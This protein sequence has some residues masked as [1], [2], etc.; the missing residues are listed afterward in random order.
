MKTARKTQKKTGAKPGTVTS[1]DGKRTIALEEFDRLFDEGSDEVDQ[2]LDWKNAKAVS[3][4][5]L[6][7]TK[8]NVDFPKWVVAALD[9]EADRIGVPRQS[10]IKVWIVQHLERLPDGTP[11]ERAS[12]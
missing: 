8:V 5:L 11:R 1:L 10:L 12:L 2:F 7:A 9:R 4:R 6:E 3:P